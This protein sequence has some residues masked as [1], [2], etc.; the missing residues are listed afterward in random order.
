MWTDAPR[1][2]G[3]LSLG[4]SSPYGEAQSAQDAAGLMGGEV[5]PIESGDDSDDLFRWIPTSA[6]NDEMVCDR[7][8][9]NVRQGSIDPLCIE[10]E[11]VSRNRR[12]YLSHTL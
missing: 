11:S 3:G 8:R 4:A 9:Q 7:I 10:I 1:R 12:L 5:G 2:F 6:D